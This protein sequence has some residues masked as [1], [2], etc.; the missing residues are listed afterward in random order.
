MIY[1]SLPFRC[2]PS[3]VAGAVVGVCGC[4]GGPLGSWAPGAGLCVRVCLGPCVCEFVAAFPGG[5]VGRGVLLSVFGG[6]VVGASPVVMSLRFPDV[7]DVTTLRLGP[8]RGSR[9]TCG[10]APRSV[11]PFG[12]L[13]VSSH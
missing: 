10:S 11:V 3:G 9:Q 2:C 7:F 6:G 13:I 4:A 5:G 1:V 12:A 8:N